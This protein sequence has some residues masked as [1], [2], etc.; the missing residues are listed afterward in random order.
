M[1]KD[2]RKD[3]RDL[4]FKITKSQHSQCPSQNSNGVDPENKSVK[5]VL[6]TGLMDLSETFKCKQIEKTQIQKH[7]FILLLIF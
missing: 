7:S 6:A 5:S 3:G 4:S 1:G 2:I